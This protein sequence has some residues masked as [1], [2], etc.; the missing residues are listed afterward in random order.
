[1]VVVVAQAH[2]AEEAIALRA[3]SGVEALGD[4]LSV[5]TS[6]T[7]SR[8]KESENKLSIRYSSCFQGAN[9]QILG[10]LD[11]IKAV[12]KLYLV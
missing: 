7:P 5:G 1:M 10:K 12:G 11:F 3:S 2:A 4:T 8:M 6:S 9:M